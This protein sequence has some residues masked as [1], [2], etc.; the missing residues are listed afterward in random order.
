MAEKMVSQNTRTTGGSPCVH[1]FNCGYQLSNRMRLDCWSRIFLYI[2]QR[3]KESYVMSGAFNSF[4]IFFYVMCIRLASVCS[5][6]WEELSA[7]WEKQIKDS[8]SISLT[9]LI[10]S[11][12]S[13]LFF[14]T[15]WY[16]SDVDEQVE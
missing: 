11:L 3:E 13:E 12:E 1:F 6:N 7:E 15:C 9:Y 10:I 14:L 16:C 4:F 5:N 8:R 2:G